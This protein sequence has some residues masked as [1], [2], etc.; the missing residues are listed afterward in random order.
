MKT[1]TAHT[2]SIHNRLDFLEKNGS[3]LCD[4]CKFRLKNRY[5][6]TERRI[7]WGISSAIDVGTTGIVES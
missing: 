2:P 3:S 6:L 1:G 7:G 4:L 5:I